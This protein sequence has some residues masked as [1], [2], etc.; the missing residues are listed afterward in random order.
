[1]RLMKIMKF[2][3]CGYL[4][5]TIKLFVL[6]LKM[7]KLLEDTKLKL[8]DNSLQLP[9]TAGASAADGC[10]RDQHTTRQST[11]AF[12]TIKIIPNNVHNI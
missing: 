4:N 6:V 7:G 2:L 1:M 10:S 5:L 12:E 9:L 3:I 8:E 11:T